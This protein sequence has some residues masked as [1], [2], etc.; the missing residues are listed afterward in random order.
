MSVPYSWTV[1]VQLRWPDGSIP[2]NQQI[3]QV[4]AFESYGDAMQDL[5]GAG[6]GANGICTL[7]FG[8]EKFYPPRTNPTLTIKVFNYQGELLHTQE[9][10]DVINNSIIPITIGGGISDIWRVYGTVKDSSALPV[11]SGTVKVFDAFY[12]PERLLG[13]QPISNTGTYEINFTSE[14]FGKTPSH[15]APNLVVRAYNNDTTVI[16][17]ATRPSPS[18]NEMVDLVADVFSSEWCISGIVSIDSA[19]LTSGSVQLFDNFEGNEYPLGA[20]ILNEC[21]YY[22]ITYLESQFQ[23]GSPRLYPELTV[24]V[25]N[26][27]GTFYGQFSVSSP[28]SKDQT[29]NINITEVGE[30][31]TVK[32]TVTNTIG[33]AVGGV[34]IAVTDVFYIN[35]AFQKT[36][37]GTAITASNGTYSLSYN[38]DLLPER[39]NLRPINILVTVSRIENSRKTVIVKSKLHSNVGSILTVDLTVDA[40]SN[41]DTSN[42]SM[43][44]GK[45]SDAGFSEVVI[46][47][48]L[49]EPEKLEYAASVTGLSES[50]ILL[51][52]TAIRLRNELYGILAQTS[53]TPRLVTAIIIYA[54]IKSIKISTLVELRSVAPDRF[55]S[56][57]VASITGSLLSPAY[58]TSLEA[59]A[60]EWQSI[61]KALLSVSVGASSEVKLFIWSEVPEDIDETVKQIFSNHAHD[62]NTFFA[63]I[64]QA[65]A[66][67]DTGVPDPDKRAAIDRLKRSFDALELADGFDLLAE[68]I[69]EFA[70]FNNMD[71]I[72]KLA[73]IEKDVWQS[74]IDSITYSPEIEWPDGIPGETIMEKRSNCATIMFKKIISLYPMV[75]FRHQLL[76]S[77]NS[78]WDDVK[79]F[80]I[81]NPEFDFIDDVPSSVPSVL[82]AKLLTIQ[83]LYRLMPRLEVVEKLIER[84]YTSALS[85]ARTNTDDFISANADITDGVDDA[86]VL[87]QAAVHAASQTIFLMGTFNRQSDFTGDSLPVLSDRFDQP[88]TS[89]A[90]GYTQSN[91]S[92]QSVRPNLATLFGNQNGC[93]CEECQSV[94]S[95]SAYMVDLLEFLNSSENRNA[96]T[97]PLTSVLFSRRTDLAETDLSCRNTNGPVSYIDLVNEVL[98]NAVCIRRFFLTD[99]EEG[100]FASLL[101][102]VAEN[103]DN[104]PEYVANIFGARGFPIDRSYTV[105]ECEGRWYITGNLWRYLVRQCPGTAIYS[106]EPWPQ[107]GSDAQLRRIKPEHTHQHAYGLLQNS[108]YP[109]I[110]PVN[111]PFVEINKFLELRNCKRYELYHVLH[112]RTDAFTLG[113]DSFC[114]FFEMTHQQYSLIANDTDSPWE[115]WGLDETENEYQIPGSARQLAGEWQWY[116]IVANVTVF[117]N[118]TGLSFD[119]LLG[120]MLTRTAQSCG[121]ISLE[122][123]SGANPEEGDLDLLWIQPENNRE[124]SFKLLARFLRLRSHLKIDIFT[125]DRL[126]YMISQGMPFTNLI[127]LLP[128]MRIAR[129]FQVSPLQAAAWLSG[130]LD[131]I[132]LGRGPSSQLEQL[133]IS[134]FESGERANLWKKMLNTVVDV[135]IRNFYVGE[136]NEKLGG[137]IKVLL[138]GLRVNYKDLSRIIWREFKRTGNEEDADARAMLQN[139]PVTIGNL[140]KMYRAADFARTLKLSVRDY[141]AILDL[142]TSRNPAAPFTASLMY[143]CKDAASKIKEYGISA[144]ELQYLLTDTGEEG[145]SWSLKDDQELETIIKIHQKMYSDAEIT[146]ESQ[147]QNVIDELATIGKIAPDLTGILLKEVLVG[148]T[149]SGAASIDDW[150]AVCSG[151]WNAS[152]YSDRNHQIPVTGAY[153]KV[154]SVKVVN[155]SDVTYEKLPSGTKSARWDGTLIISENGRYSFRYELRTANPGGEPGKV[156]I[157]ITETIRSI[158]PDSG[159]VV[160]T[161]VNHDY[162]DCQ[163]VKN[164]DY[165][166]TIEWQAAEGG[167]DIGILDLAIL[168]KR[169][170][171][172]DAVAELLGPRNIL[173]AKSCGMK[174]FN[175]CA[176]IVQK[177]GMLSDQLRYITSRHVELG[178]F[179]LNDIPV[180]PGSVIPWSQCSSLF[181][182]Y[183]L[184]RVLSFTGKDTTLFSLWKEALK[185]GRL[186]SVYLKTIEKETG[187]WIEDIKTIARTF[188]FQFADYRKPSTWKIL[189]NA[190]R[191]L[192]RIG[193]TAEFGYEISTNDNTFLQAEALVDSIRKQYAGTDWI[194]AAEPVRDYM[195]T[196]QRDALSAYL[197]GRKKTLGPNDRSIHVANLILLLNH[198]LGTNLKG[199]SYTSEVSEAVSRLRSLCGL[200]QGDTVNEDVWNVLDGRHNFINNSAIYAWYLIDVDMSAS[201]KTTRI[202]QANCSIQMLVQRAKLNLEEG[203]KLNDKMSQQWMWMKNYRLWEANRRIFLYPENWLEP[204]LR[205][206]KT[207]LFKEM[208]SL[209]LQKD[210]DNET[211]EGV[212]RNYVCG[213]NEIANLEV[214][215]NHYEKSVV[216][217]PTTSNI[218]NTGYGGFT[219][220]Y[221]NQG[222]S[223]NNDTEQGTNIHHVVART[224]HHPHVYYYRCHHSVAGG[225]NFWTPWEK[226]DLDISSEVVLPVP[227]NNKLYLFWPIIEV[228]EEDITIKD[229][230]TINVVKYDIKF[231]WSEYINGSWGAKR[232][233]KEGLK[234]EII[235][236]RLSDLKKENPYD[237]FNFRALVKKDKIEIETFVFN[238]YVNQYTNTTAL[239]EVDSYTSSLGILTFYFDNSIEINQ[240]KVEAGSAYSTMSHYVPNGQ[241][242]RH[243]FLLNDEAEKLQYPVDHAADPTL[244]EAVPDQ[245]RIAHPYPPYFNQIFVPFFYQEKGKSFYFRPL[246]E[247]AIPYKPEGQQPGI[248]MI[249]NFNHPMSIEL[250][251]KANVASIDSLFR[252]STQASAIHDEPLGYSIIENSYANYIGSN[253]F[254]SIYQPTH[255]I[256]SRYPLPIVDFSNDSAYGVYNWE[257][258]FHLPLLIADHLRRDF[259]HEDAMRWLNYIFNPTNDTILDDE[260]AFC[261]G[262]PASAR[263]WNFL[264]FFANRGAEESLYKMLSYRRGSNEDTRLGI[265]IEE[266]KNNP[267]KPHLIARNR[268]AAYQKSVVMKYLDNL[269]SWGDGLFRVDTMESINEALQLYVY[270]S[271]ILGEKPK[272]IPPLHEVP[273]LTYT[274]LKEENLDRF[275]NAIIELEN[276]I[277]PVPPVKVRL[278]R[279]RTTSSHYYNRYSYTTTRTVETIPYRSVQLMRMATAM[280]YFCIPKNDRLI[281]YWNTVEDRLFKIRHSLNIDGVK[282]DIPLFAPPIDPGLLARAVS[283]GVD[284]GSVIRDMQV[285]PSHY[286]YSVLMQ[287]AVE[288]CNELKSFGSELLSAIEK[289][290]SEQIMLLRNSQ[291]IELYKLISEVKNNSVKEAQKTL[292]GLRKSRELTETRYNFYK[293]IQKISPLE[294]A[295]FVTLGA[296]GVVNLVSQFMTMASGKVSLIP[297]LYLG[298]VAGPLPGGV[299]LSKVAGGEKT[300]GGLAKVASGLAQTANILDRTA[301]IL[302]T[303]A[304]YQR[305]WEEWKL[306]ES[307]AKKELE[308][309][310][311]QILGAEIRV[312]I[313]ELEV[314]NHE[315]QI[316]QA[317][318]LKEVMESKFSSEQLYQWMIEQ[319]TITY[320]A[321]YDTALR[322]A[323]KVERVYQFELGN[324]AS[325]FI[326]PEIWNSAKKGLLAGERL[327]LSLRQMDMA[328]LENNKREFEITKT[329]SLRSI[330]PLSLLRLR[331]TGTC[332]FSVSEELFDLDFPGHFFR[333]IKSVRVTIPCITGPYTSICARLRITNNKVRVSTDLLNGAYTP[334]SEIAERRFVS[335][336]VTM[337]SIATGSANMDSGMFELSFRDERYL[338]F[339]GAGVISDW[340]LELPDELRQF[341]YQSIS[342]VVIHISYTA[343]ESTDLAFKK[344]VKAHLMDYV[345]NAAN[346][347][348]LIS[349]KDCFA[350]QYMN[351]LSGSSAVIPLSERFLHP[352]VADYVKTHENTP[353]VLRN[354]CLYVVLKEKIVGNPTFTISL[355]DQNGDPYEAETVREDYMDPTGFSPDFSGRVFKITYNNGE[356][357]D[358]LPIGEWNFGRLQGIGSD[359]IENLYLYFDYPSMAEVLE[360]TMAH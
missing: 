342:D 236:W 103:L 293:E 196:L 188:N 150:V 73:T 212:V 121:T 354:A 51:C 320:N 65:L 221:G 169:V 17:E 45:L 132:N 136:E 154:P 152:F 358:G 214:V 153:S 157:E 193:I 171:N 185:P 213:L 286:R 168:W 143:M 7:Y 285:A 341:D 301:G 336:P 161:T 166:V 139:I 164:G 63:E 163:L 344:A 307:L 149:A 134:H 283:A 316:E 237:L 254:E 302:G 360:P 332:S 243:N 47:A 2:T 58:T 319:L 125:L 266:W 333:R 249:E 98:E 300:G 34:E 137:D 14:T 179:D 296:A 191:L 291:E 28:P 96:A 80:I 326:K 208:E 83:R 92:A 115:L 16:A 175:K 48:M 173:F 26:S 356:E 298:A 260:E 211:V 135:D 147:E 109:S 277:P 251:K 72:S 67:P 339:E 262:L 108:V 226:V 255:L 25:Y 244:L 359:K 61:Y 165:S 6:V 56:T 116:N 309:L 228:T 76:R 282:R 156:R 340:T 50:D 113:D 60:I 22:Q 32:G 275:S 122:W 331:E 199:D 355:Y 10:S 227:F 312:Q 93:K 101:G 107:T 287:K 297:D 12:T 327:M 259:R 46:L 55:H 145:I 274:Q 234:F 178:V 30:I 77:A 346:M 24:K 313:T 146:R 241:R 36:V 318:A 117:L 192:D 84:K 232:I 170:D 278:W 104:I 71:T 57:L 43:V 99:N 279:T 20:A 41:A 295:Q 142:V 138:A 183:T 224:F 54:I 258:F 219:T 238:T 91:F 328:Y 23:H 8:R 106:V 69:V 120:L 194:T 35:N 306:Q 124:Q 222:N 210:L 246:V 40:P 273:G 52:G 256:N 323:K 189:S 218:I 180:V 348:N 114:S 253:W 88:I 205:D 42:A 148:T 264:P 357:V 176:F 181:D 184:N 351:I 94:F 126:L 167:T 155:G 352:F 186:G 172:P 265:L 15:N 215:G 281:G 338:P 267:F 242:L 79:P 102:M 294:Y 317:Q 311:K 284:I 233:S 200:Y 314:K 100:D 239:S 250:F 4:L 33:A 162:T 39:Q 89:Y 112:E 118:R 216:K 304:S 131:N 87:H 270:A 190:L 151:G 133:F 207:P 129:E 158:D 97:V 223:S 59:I 128:V 231:S 248:L 11:T 182:M 111:I 18:Q 288:L 53:V 68:K 272:I 337:T 305:R 206:D 329:I 105:Q 27:S 66:D 229:D 330:D 350:A 160:E 64:E 308:Q 334:G 240:K 289:K 82:R 343:R 49:D 299:T 19:P 263:F 31:Y 9:F 174:Q 245:F 280:H 95:P 29:F 5:C 292:D 38:P 198:T 110:L 230:R 268:I 321:I 324:I 1:H 90:T 220:Q 271:E 269:I 353:P 252:R 70:R 144:D 310:D 37:I 345:Q 44:F 140:G 290:D 217:K 159:E 315:K 130:K 225:R 197:L 21:G 62:K 3:S 349:I 195:R 81:S 13:E 127:D 247:N 209:L 86:L 187:W 235:A 261:F 74:I 123:E 75:R 85:I 201:V 141:Y 257:L 204:E 202:V 335:N 276:Y 347:P 322:M 78:L 325:S 177:F 203:I 303:Q 119:E